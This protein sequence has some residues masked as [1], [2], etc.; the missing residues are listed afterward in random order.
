MSMVREEGRKINSDGA[1]H[2]E[3]YRFFGDAGE[4]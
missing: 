2:L 1:L 3:D 4:M